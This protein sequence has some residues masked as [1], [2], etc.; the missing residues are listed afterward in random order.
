M[1]DKFSGL[2]FFRIKTIINNIIKNKIIN[3]WVSNVKVNAQDIM[4]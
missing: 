3:E 4:I 1:I 2:D